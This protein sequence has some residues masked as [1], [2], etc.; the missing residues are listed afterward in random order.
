MKET[1]RAYEFEGEEGTAVVYEG[2]TPNGTSVII[3]IPSNTPKNVNH[4]KE[5]E[6]LLNIAKRFEEGKGPDGSPPKV[7]KKT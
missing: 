3:L 2:K 5:A 6:K 7:I 1:E 4:D